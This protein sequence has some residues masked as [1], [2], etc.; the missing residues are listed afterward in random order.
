MELCNMMNGEMEWIKEFKSTIWIACIVCITFGI[1]CSSICS[2]IIYWV[3]YFSHA[4]LNTASSSKLVLLVFFKE[5][6]TRMEK[7]D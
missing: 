7:N 4:E 5:R 2:S 1:Y 6:Y 3:H